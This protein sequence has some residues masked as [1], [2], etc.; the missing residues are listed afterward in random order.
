MC[1]VSV[2]F[3]AKLMSPI[4]L[5]EC[6]PFIY[7]QAEPGLYYYRDWHPNRNAFPSAGW[8]RDTLYLFAAVLHFDG[9]TESLAGVDSLITTRSKV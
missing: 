1:V 2:E 5:A 7:L 9:V 6:I 4:L 8:L 3:A